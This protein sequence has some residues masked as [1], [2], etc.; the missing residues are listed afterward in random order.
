MLATMSLQTQPGAPIQSPFPSLAR[1][2]AIGL[3]A[4]T[5]S[6]SAFLLFQIQPI[7]GRLVLPWFGGSAAVWST[8]M[9]FFQA[10]LLVGYLYAHAVATRLQVKT[11]RWLHLVLLGV[12]AAFLPIA[13][14]ADWKPVDARDPTLQILTVLA[15]AAGLPYFV[16]SATSPLLQAW[17][18]REQSATP[19]YRLFALS[20]LGSM[21]ALLTYPVWVE[22]ALA[23][24]QQSIAWSWGYAL[25]AIACA[26]VTWRA[27]T[28][29]SVA[30]HAAAAD[31]RKPAR[32]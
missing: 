30:F 4:M 11:Q 17:F 20:N 14:N 23:L 3:F 32:M 6:S 28:L 15:S 19:A 25:F 24:R 27:G 8:C 29:P 31:Q 2:L 7:M 5:V 21:A 1:K 18:A 22:P 12:S 9:L 10:L 16:L 26:A 13:M